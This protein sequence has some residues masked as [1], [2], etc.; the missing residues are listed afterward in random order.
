[1]IEVTDVKNQL[2]VNKTNVQLVPSDSGVRIIVNEAKTI[3]APNDLKVVLNAVAKQGLPGPPGPAGSG[4]DLNY[5]HTQVGASTTWSVVHNL[6][7]YPS[8]TVIDSGD[9]EVIGD[10]QYLSANSLQISFTAAF[11]GKAYLN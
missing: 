3:L 4:G 1:M 11:S 7:K 8:V 2:I 10:V 6:G 5:T 9:T